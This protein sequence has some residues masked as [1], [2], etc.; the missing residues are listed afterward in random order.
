MFSCRFVKTDSTF[1]L[2]LSL[3]FGYILPLCRFTDFV[4]FITLFLHFFLNLYFI[5]I[6]TEYILTIT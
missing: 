2:L 4:F 5:A 3:Q 1:F 6:F